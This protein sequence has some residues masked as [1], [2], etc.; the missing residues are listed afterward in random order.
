MPTTHVSPEQLEHMARE[1]KGLARA[2]GA[3]TPPT[4]GACGLTGRAAVER[5]YEAFDREWGRFVGQCHSEVEVMAELVELAAEAY[6]TQD[7]R[8]AEAAATSATVKVGG[9]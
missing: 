5:A 8:V 2:F 3:A 6:R 4:L 9:R 1:I 7:G